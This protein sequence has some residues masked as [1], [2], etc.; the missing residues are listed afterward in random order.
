MKNA[1]KYQRHFFHPPEPSTDW[2]GAPA[3][4]KAPVW[5]SVDLLEGNQG[6]Y[7]PMSAGEKLEYFL[8]LVNMGIKEIEVGF[9]AASATEFNF[10]RSLAERR[11]LPLDVALQVFTHAR[12]DLIR[13]TFDAIRGIPS[14][15]VHLCGMRPDGKHEQPAKAA[16]EALLDDIVESARLMSSLAEESGSAIRFEFSPDG[17]DEAGP[18]LLLH[19][20]NAV[21]DIWKPSEDKKAIINLADCAETAMPHIFASMVEYIGRRLNSRENIIL[22]VH[23]HNDHGCAVSSAEMALLAGA[24]RIECSLFGN[25]ERSGNADLVTLALNL[26]SYG[27]D[28]RL[29]LSNLP[30]IRKIFERLTG[31]SVP[32]RQ[33]YSGDFVF[34]DFSS[35]NMVTKSLNWHREKHLSSWNIPYLPIDPHDIGRDFDSD[36]VRF[37]SESGKGGICYL[38]KQH[39]GIAVPEKMRDDVGSRVKQISGE[40]H[41]VLTPKNILDIFEENYLYYIPFFGIEDCSFRQLGGIIAEATIVHA[42]KKAVVSAHGNGRLDAVSNIIKQY[43]GISYELSAYEEYALSRGS[44][45]KAMAFVCVTSAGMPFWGA[46]SDEDILKASIQALVVAV[47]KLPNMKSEAGIYDERL[48]AMQNYIQT[49]YQTVTLASL[50]AH[51][52]LSAP[53]ASKYIREKSGRT[54]GEILTFIRMRKAQVLLIN[55]T[56]TVETVSYAIG[57]PN[58]E[59]FTRLFKKKFGLT[60][61]HFRNKNK[62]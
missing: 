40:M 9:P 15:I 8:M 62:R 57:Y 3:V 30:H 58:V 10:V 52:N 35:D 54:F 49:N 34:S 56:M 32:E 18:D 48:M 45:S 43:F 28:P 47:N 16:N 37:S 38:L 27:T 19:A 21:V 44:S 50:A 22:S 51:F 12:E 60:P 20:C 17:F 39:Y 23:P 11:L 5:C 7:V 36:I 33:P 14:A 29:D 1:Q 26:Y 25:G 42:D 53:Y 31:M 59:H 46:G 61:T 2:I 13:T 4:N 55:D 6:L 24:Q 41:R